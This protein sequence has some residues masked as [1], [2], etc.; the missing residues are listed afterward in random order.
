[1]FDL[2]SGIHNDI[3]KMKIRKYAV[4]GLIMIVARLVTND[5][6]IPVNAQ[7]QLKDLA[8]ANPNQSR[9]SFQFKFINNLIIV[10][11]IINDSDTLHFILDTGLSTSIMTEVSWGDTLSL[12]Y[13]RQVK[14]KG[15]GQGE[16]V[17]ALHS[18]GNNFNI[19]GIQGAN[20]DLYVLLQNVFNLSAIFGTKVHGLIGYNMFKNF[21]VEI[22]YDRKVITFHNPDKYKPSR[23]RRRG[24]TLPLIIHQTKPYVYGAIT[25]NDGTEIPVKLL[26]DT[27]ASHALWIDVESDENINYPGKTADV[28]LGKGLNGDIYGKIGR[29]HQFTIGDFT[30]DEPIVAFPDSLSAGNAIGRD[31]RN[32]SLG[33]EILRRFHVIIDYPNSLITLFPNNQYR[34]E[35]R[36][37]RSGIEIEAPLPGIPYYIISNVRKDSPADKAG[38]RKGDEIKYING[39]NSLTLTINEMYQFFQKKPGYKL[40][41]N[42]TREGYHFKVVLFLDDFI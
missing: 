23:Y 18:Y 22:N 42:V 11:V 37:N 38:L 39:K 5:L 34:S 15:L 19:S 35:F 36:L 10:P 7:N 17:D 16:P 1:M 20:Q 28:F 40:K 26:L 8:F 33:S 29:M 41:L 24:I 21:I 2:N 30:F 3:G 32:G 14:L 9:I 6:A 25:M 13:T 31:N 27:G 12:N 4:I